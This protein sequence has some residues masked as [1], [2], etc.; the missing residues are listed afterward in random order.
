MR[1]CSELNSAC[2]LYES[3]NEWSKIAQ[4]DCLHNQKPLRL[5]YCP[6]ISLS[7]PKQPSLCPLQ[8]NST[9]SYLNKVLQETYF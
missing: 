1:V 9:H 7:P 6:F 4:T 3:E 5:L 8:K 2:S